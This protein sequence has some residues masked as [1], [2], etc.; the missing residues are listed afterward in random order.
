MKNNNQEVLTFSI[1]QVKRRRRYNS[2]DF[3]INNNNIYI[4]KFL[5]LLYYCY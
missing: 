1:Y 2:L 4:I 3:L 5:F